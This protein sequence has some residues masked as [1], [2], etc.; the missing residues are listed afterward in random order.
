ML[1][2]VLECGTRTS[3]KKKTIRGNPLTCLP[4]TE[5][6]FPR[7]IPFRCPFF[8]KAA[9]CHRSFLLL[10]WL[11]RYEGRLIDD[12]F[13]NGPRYGLQQRVAGGRGAQP[14]GWDQTGGL[15]LS[16]DGAAG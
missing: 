6:C 1:E 7:H 2:S 11:F 3:P 12:D 4:F 8:Q 13:E 5:W 14:R 9:V 15:D 10:H 16:P